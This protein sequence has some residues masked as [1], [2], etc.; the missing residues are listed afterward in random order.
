[1]LSMLSHTKFG[2]ILEVCAIEMLT[3]IQ[4]YLSNSYATTI[5]PTLKYTLVTTEMKFSSNLQTRNEALHARTVSE[6]EPEK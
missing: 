3:R 5:V 1:M 2:V 4:R 6:N